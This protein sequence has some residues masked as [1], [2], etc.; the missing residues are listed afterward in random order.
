MSSGNKMLHFVKVNSMLPTAENGIVVDAEAAPMKRNRMKALQEDLEL[1]RALSRVSR[2]LREVVDCEWSSNLDNKPP[3]SKM[4][5]VKKYLFFC[6]HEYLVVAVSLEKWRS[7][8]S[9]LSKSDKV[10]E[11]CLELLKKSCEMLLRRCSEE[12]EDARTAKLNEK[13]ARRMLVEEKSVQRLQREVL[14]E[15]KEKR[16]REEEKM[17]LEQRMKAR[18]AGFYSTKCRQ[19]KVAFM[20][21][22]WGR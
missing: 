6:N 14:K 16:R 20:N 12:I 4:F 13:E 9:K 21:K 7:L 5:L 2:D 3:V 17:L 8:L 10:D 1:A 18:T 19:G 11:R 22:D 15:E